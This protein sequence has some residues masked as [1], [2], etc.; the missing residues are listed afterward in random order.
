MQ[1]Y[2]NARFLT[3]SITGV[4]RYAVELIKALDAL[5]GK[6]EID[7]KRYSFCLLAPMDVKYELEL[8]HIPLRRVGYLSGHLWEQIELPFHARG[9]LLVSLCNSGPLLRP[10]QIVTIHDASIFIIPESYSF[11]F[12]SLYKLLLPILGRVA[13][14][15]ITVS[16]FAKSDLEKHCHINSNKI[17]VIY[18]GKEHVLSSHARLPGIDTLASTGGRFVLAVGSLTYNRNFHSAIKAMD[19]LGDDSYKLVIAGGSSSKIF[20]E[21]QLQYAYQVIYL[22]NM[23]IGELRALYEKATCLLVPSFYES[24]GFPA[25]EAMACGCPVIASNIGSLP[26]I[27]GDA[28]IYCDPHDVKDIAAK[29][30][31]VMSNEELREKMRQKGLERAKLYSWEKCARETFGVM[32]KVLNQ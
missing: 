15:V 30:K 25:L 8:K 2:I 14:Y 27:C 1:I 9:G 29:I 3:Q 4:Q 13:K 17:L 20:G 26:E 28:A 7:S 19:L 18:H 12:R 10:K 32:K 6:G 11:L 23:S 24:F 31:M 22:G 16:N 5:I 21:N